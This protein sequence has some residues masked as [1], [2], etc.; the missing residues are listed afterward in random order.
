MHFQVL[1]VRPGPREVLDA[2]IDD[3]V[4]SNARVDWKGVMRA[5]RIWLFEQL[6][7]AF[8]AWV[9]PAPDDDAE[10]PLQWRLT[11][12]AQGPALAWRHGDA[13][14]WTPTTSWEQLD[15]ARRARIDETLAAILDMLHALLLIYDD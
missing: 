2:L 11:H 12:T 14:P 10:N 1:H 6:S 5:D 7:D 4:F 13:A 15:G 9:A 8:D 3:E